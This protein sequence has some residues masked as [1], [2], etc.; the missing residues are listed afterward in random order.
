MYIL[1]KSYLLLM[2]YILFLYVFMSQL[3]YSII[4]HDTNPSNG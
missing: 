4:G 1:I 2:Y 3:K